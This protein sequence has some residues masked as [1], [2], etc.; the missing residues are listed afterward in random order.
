MHAFFATHFAFGDAFV[1]YRATPFAFVLSPSLH[2]CLACFTA[3]L[4]FF[5]NASPSAIKTKQG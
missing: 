3:M 2:A 1:L 4:L 5:C